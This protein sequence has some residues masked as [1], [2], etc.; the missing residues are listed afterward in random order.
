MK[1]QSEFKHFHSRKC[2][3]KC[4]LRNGV[5][6]SRPQ[7]VNWNREVIIEGLLY[8]CDQVCQYGSLC[9]KPVLINQTIF[10]S[11]YKKMNGQDKADVKLLTI[12]RDPCPPCQ[13]IIHANG[14]MMQL[15]ELR[16]E[17]WVM[18]SGRLIH[19]LCLV[20]LGLSVGPMCCCMIGRSKYW[21]GDSSPA[22]NYG[23]SAMHYSGWNFL[24]FLKP[25]HSSLAEP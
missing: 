6:L 22:L 1:F 3:W 18:F 24:H 15:D 8:C 13:A 7:C 21:M 4:R 16:S 11:C 10:Q 25:M 20:A 17:A 12:L 23:L 2:I 14:C 5:H 9:P 19:S